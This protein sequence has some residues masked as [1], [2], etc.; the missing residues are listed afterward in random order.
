[1]KKDGF[2]LIE[3]VGSLAI[4]SILLLISFKGFKY[5]ESH[6]EKIQNVSV[7]YNVKDILSFSKKYCYENGKA[8]E[9][10]FDNC[11]DFNKVYFSSEGNIIKT[12]YVNEELKLLEANYISK[13]KRFILLNINKYGY[14]DPYT[15]AVINKSNEIRKIVIQVGG[16]L[17][18]IKDE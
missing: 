6:V 15:I 5:Y 17:I 1:M 14:I 7:L 9:I 4:L 12:M 10:Y 8:G 11:D 2:T 3:V 13:D 18:Y 16:N